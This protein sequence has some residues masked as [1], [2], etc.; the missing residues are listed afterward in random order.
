MK[1][2]IW[3]PS[4]WRFLHAVTFAY[5]ESPSEEHKDAAR[6]LFRSLKLMLP[7][8]DCCTHYC[9]GFALDP[10][11]K[12]LESRDALSQWLVAFHN[13]VNARLGKA[14]YSYD[15]AKAEFI[16]DDEFC[17][18][19]STCGDG[20]EASGKSR[21]SGIKWLAILVAIVVVACLLRFR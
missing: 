11:D 7:C 8:G 2:S 4:A 10:V 9:A 3:G 19:Q 20:V 12:H 15:K 5:P 16:T 17:S 13:K 14:Q 6:S 21:G 18:A 1:T